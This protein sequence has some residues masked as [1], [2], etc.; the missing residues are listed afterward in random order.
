LR[1][2]RNKT[3]KPF[4]LTQYADITPLVSFPTSGVMNPFQ[5]IR[6]LQ[7]ILA[8]KKNEKHN[9]NKCNW[10]LYWEYTHR[11]NSWKVLLSLIHCIENIGWGGNATHT[12]TKLKDYLSLNRLEFKHPKFEITP[13]CSKSDAVLD[14]LIL[15]KARGIDEISFLRHSLRILSRKSNILNDLS[16][17]D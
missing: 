15:G 3:I 13:K 11:E 5:S 2:T 9:R 7:E 4:P 16:I 8:N 17:R 14:N 12:S 1:G 6:Y 10:D